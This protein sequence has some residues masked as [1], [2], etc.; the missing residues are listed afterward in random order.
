MNPENHARSLAHFDA[1]REK[2]D[3][4]LNSRDAYSSRLGTRRIDRDRN[5]RVVQIDSVECRFLLEQ[6]GVIDIQGEIADLGQD[7]LPA[8]AIVDLEIFR[9]QAPKRVQRKSLN[10]DFQTKAVEFLG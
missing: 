7:P 2:I 6:I 1:S 5:L 3:S 8:I 10:P 9:H 4:R